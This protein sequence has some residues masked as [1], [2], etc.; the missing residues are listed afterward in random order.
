[1][2]SSLSFDSRDEGT[3]AEA[4]RVGKGKGKEVAGKRTSSVVLLP[5]KQPG[6]Q[7]L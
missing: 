5:A 3:Q 4:K 7:S 2:L 6:K 1:M